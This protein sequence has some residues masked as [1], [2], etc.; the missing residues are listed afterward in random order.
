M[1]N[2]NKK[3]MPVLPFYQYQQKPQKDFQFKI[4]PQANKETN[5][6]SC[7]SKNVKGSASNSIETPKNLSRTKSKSNLAPVNIE[8][9]SKRPTICLA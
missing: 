7:K 3:S 6:N 9:H 5:R 4:F 8:H 2:R 1:L